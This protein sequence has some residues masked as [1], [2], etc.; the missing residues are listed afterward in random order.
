ML[1]MFAKEINFKYNET[2]VHVLKSYLNP[3][4]IQQT[5]VMSIYLSHNLNI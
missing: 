2:E 4:I 1:D 5:S 3:E